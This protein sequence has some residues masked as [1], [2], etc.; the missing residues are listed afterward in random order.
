LTHEI[1]AS[2][3]IGVLCVAYATNVGALHRPDE[4]SR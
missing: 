4:A 1:V 3:W 2:L